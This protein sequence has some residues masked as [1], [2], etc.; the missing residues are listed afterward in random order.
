MGEISSEMEMALSQLRTLTVLVI[1]SNPMDLE[2]IKKTCNQCSNHV[3]AVAESLLAPNLLRNIKGRIDLVLME[4]HMPLIDGYEF[5]QFVKQEINVPLVLMSSDDNKNSVTKAIELGAFDYLIK[6]LREDQLNQLWRYVVMKSVS[7][8][9]TKVKDNDCLEDDN[10][11][12]G[13]KVNSQFAPSPDIE[14][15]NCSSRQVDVVDKSKNSD[16]PNRKTRVVWSS[17]L[18]NRFL[19]AIHE[20]GLA[21][22]LLVLNFYLSDAVPKKILA[23]MNVPGLQRG[24]VGSHLQKYRKALETKSKNVAQRQQQQNERK[25]LILRN[26]AGR[27]GASG[28]THLQPFPATTL[29]DFHPGLTGN[30]VPIREDQSHQ[31]IQLA[32]HFNGEQALAHGHSLSS[33]HDIVNPQNS[34]PDTVLVENQAMLQSTG[35]LDDAFRYTSRSPPNT[36]PVENQTMFKSMGTSD[37]ASRYSSLSSPNPVLFENQAMLQRNNMQQGRMEQSMM[38][39]HQIHPINFQSPSMMIS[40][41]SVTQNNSFGMNIDHDLISP[42]PSRNS[43]GIVQIQGGNNT[44][45]VILTG[46]SSFPQFQ[47][48]GLSSASVGPFAAS[49]FDTQVPYVS[50]P[51][52]FG[53]GVDEIDM[54]DPTEYGELAFGSSA[55]DFRNQNIDYQTNNQGAA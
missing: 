19:N 39:H 26:T 42:Q 16:S 25:S 46:T 17:D 24:H 48:T 35:I 44:G 53:V 52:T 8:E 32:N 36:V 28:R 4:V 31:N 29:S 5:L 14:R 37:D 21:T 18:H 45:E 20:L 7:E 40:G 9:N 3:I 30:M 51:N 13:M 34:S 54:F 22:L 27:M 10:K 15:I 12:R 23:L 33:F 38:Q 55:S 41:N 43:V 6:P 50:R 49:M 1:D 11:K 2:C 47:N